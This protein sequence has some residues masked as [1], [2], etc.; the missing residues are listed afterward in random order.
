[1]DDGLQGQPA[2]IRELFSPEKVRKIL[3]RANKNSAK[4][5]KVPKT[6]EGLIEM[7]ENNGFPK[8]YQDTYLGH[9]SI[10]TTGNMLL[11]LIKQKLKFQRFRD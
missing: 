7:Y 2:E 11:S 3:Q 4:A 1:M 10:E 9:V 8:Q 5:L 6:V